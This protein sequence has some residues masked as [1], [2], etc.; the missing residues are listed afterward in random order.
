MPFRPVRDISICLLHFKKVQIP[1]LDNFVYITGTKLQPELFANKILF[2][3][4]KK[5]RWK[6][7]YNIK[8]KVLKCLLPSFIHMLWLL[9]DLLGII[10]MKGLISFPYLRFLALLPS[11]DNS[12]NNVLWLTAKAMWWFIFQLY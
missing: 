1:N 2:A 9:S 8:N 3:Q 11:N 6:L 7:T 5:N 4:I 10:I 12:N